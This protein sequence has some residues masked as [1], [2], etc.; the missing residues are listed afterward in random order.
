M[1]H[2]KKILPVFFFCSLFSLFGRD[3][4]ITVVDVDLGLP[5]EGAVVRSF[6]GTQY[7]C[8]RNGKARIAVPDDRQVVIQGS[9]PGYENGRL[10]I[11][12]GANAFTMGLR[13]SGIM[14]NRELVIEAAKPGSSET[15]TGR[16]VALSGRDI[17]QTGEIGIIEDVMSSIKLLPG[18][19]YAGF[20]N[21]VPSIRGGDPMDTTAALDGYYIFNPYYWGGGFSIFDPRMVQSARLSHGVF[22][23]RYGN[24]ISGILEITSK[25]PSSTET[26]FELGASTS[27]A[28]FNLS[29]PLN[30]K[31]GLLF[32]GRVTYYDPF[33]W[34]AKQ[35]AKVYEALDAVNSIRVAPYIRGG[36][37][38]GNYRFLDNLELQATGFWGMDGI[39]VTFENSSHGDLDSDSTIR[40]DWT[41]YQGF[42]TAGLLW[43]PR[44]DMLLKFTAGTGYEDAEVDGDFLNN[45]YKK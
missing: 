13:L 11:T 25:K 16:S 6:D 21:A 39:G 27:A 28:S 15:S 5:L 2:I 31:G 19:G 41:N 8:D 32:M 29:L 24:T 26:E 37:I 10:V 34:A 9:Y 36:T 22:S 14:E 44:N 17:T 1:K 20:F 45:I 30:G 4:E 40:F 35:A 33:I 3:I 43:N 42:I 12:V 38:T 18:V 23:T 7:V